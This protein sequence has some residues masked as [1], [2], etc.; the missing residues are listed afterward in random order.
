MIIFLTSSTVA[1]TAYISRMYTYHDNTLIIKCIFIFVFFFKYKIKQ[2]ILVK[3]MRLPD[4]KL[5]PIKNHQSYN[6]RTSI[7]YENFKAEQVKFGRNYF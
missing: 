6:D 5:Y 3:V 1:G 2:K 4:F 7:I